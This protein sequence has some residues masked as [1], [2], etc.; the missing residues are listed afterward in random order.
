MLLQ[1]LLRRM[2]TNPWVFIGAVL[3]FVV[4][5]AAGYTHHIDP[6]KH[7]SVVLPASG[8]VE[9]CLIR[10]T[11]EVVSLPVDLETAT[12]IAIAHC[13]YE[14][15]AERN[16]VKPRSLAGFGSDVEAQ[17]REID[18][19]RLNHVRQLIVRHRS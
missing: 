14:I 7:R 17:F 12:Q 15:R 6:F 16:D 19:S 10:E 5:V 2:E 18:A 4:I 9:A 11:R 8:A 3:T 13:A 1:F